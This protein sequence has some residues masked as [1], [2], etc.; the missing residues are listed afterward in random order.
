MHLSYNAILLYGVDH[1]VF[2]ALLLYFHV[3]FD[4]TPG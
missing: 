2:D 4:L 1:V 3:Q